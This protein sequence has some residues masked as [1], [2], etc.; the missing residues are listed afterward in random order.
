VLTGSAAPAD[1][2][3]RHTGAGRL[4]R[5]RIA[6]EVKL[7]AGMIDE[8]AA[9]LRRFAERGYVRDDGVAV[10]PIATLGP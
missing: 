9:T 8:G 2:V 1:D 4:S 5:P 7:G 3:T 6:V 10:V